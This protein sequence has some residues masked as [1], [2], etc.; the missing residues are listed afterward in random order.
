MEPTG[1][2]LPDYMASHCRKQYCY[3]SLLWKVR[4]HI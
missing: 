1:A 3:Y 2:Y 4:Y